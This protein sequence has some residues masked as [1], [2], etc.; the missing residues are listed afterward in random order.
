MF[1]RVL[2]PERHATRNR[3]RAEQICLPSRLWPE[4]LQPGRAGAQ[5][6]GACAGAGGRVARCPRPALPVVAPKPALGSGS[7]PSA[8]A[9]Q[10]LAE[11]ALAFHSATVRPRAADSRT[12]VRRRVARGQRCLPECRRRGSQPERIPSARRIY[13]APGQVPLWARHRCL[14]DRQI[15]FCDRPICRSGGR[16]RRPARRRRGPATPAGTAA[17]RHCLFERK[18]SLSD[19]EIC[20]SEGDRCRSEQQI[21]RSEHQISPSEGQIS[22]SEQQSSCSEGQCSPSEGQISPSTR[23]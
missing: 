14:P 6:G 23:H 3:A 5:R 16:G 15:C 7:L 20:P 22:P 2:C 11:S 19:G 1:S 10:V 18:I 8:A 12:L 13:I 4:R 21:S 9:A 17:R